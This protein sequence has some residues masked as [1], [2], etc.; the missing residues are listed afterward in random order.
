M[1]DIY[2]KISMEKLEMKTLKIEDTESAQSL[3]TSLLN[4]VDIVTF[5]NKTYKINISESQQI[6]EK[7]FP[8]FGFIK[9]NEDEKITEEE[10]KAVQNSIIRDIEI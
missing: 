9:L 3:F 2:V 10:I 1:I 6:Q 8:G 5:K 7:D 4:G